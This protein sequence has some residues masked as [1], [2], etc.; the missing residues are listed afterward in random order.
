MS[1]DAP[2]KPSFWYAFSDF[3][4]AAQGAKAEKESVIPYGYVN[5]FLVDTY[6]VYNICSGINICQHQ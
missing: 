2:G 1:R 3:L 6:I 5:L 4:G